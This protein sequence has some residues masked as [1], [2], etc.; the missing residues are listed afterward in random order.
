MCPS[1]T[2]IS[3][4]MYVCIYENTKAIKIKLCHYILHVTSFWLKFK[5]SLCS[6]LN[7]DHFTRSCVNSHLTHLHKKAFGFRMSPV[8]QRVVGLGDNF[9]F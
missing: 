4:H 3:K 2:I 9:L 7:V 8:E 5:F 6:F 1:L